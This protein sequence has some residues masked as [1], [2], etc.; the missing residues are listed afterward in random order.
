MFPVS[1]RGSLCIRYPVTAI[2]LIRSCNDVLKQHYD[3]V[4]LAER[5]VI[6][7]R[8]F[9]SSKAIR[10]KLD[11]LSIST[12]ARFEVKGRADE[13][14]LGY[15]FSMWGGVTMMLMIGPIGA[16]LAGGLQ[17]YFYRLAIFY[18]AIFIAL[19]LSYVR[20]A[21]AVDGCVRKALDGASED[22]QQSGSQ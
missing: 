13:V 8:S 21:W 14:V 15:Y 3:N 5:T 1:V 7:K 9:L 22:P 16:L 10:N 4:C 12:L 17:H 18:T 6:G 2:G 20:F 11:P 19:V